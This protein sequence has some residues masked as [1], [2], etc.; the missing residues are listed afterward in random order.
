MVTVYLKNGESVQMP[1]EHLEDFIYANQDKIDTRFH[2]R[3]GS[4][5]GN[6]PSNDT[7]SS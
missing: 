4:G 5:R 6:V 7:A 1:L 3:R 2:Q